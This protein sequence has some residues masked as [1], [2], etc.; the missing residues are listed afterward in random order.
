[1]RT[2]PE[3]STVKSPRSSPGGSCLAKENFR[4]LSPLLLSP[5]RV[6]TSVPADLSSDIE[7]GFV[8]S[9]GMVNTGGGTVTKHA[10]IKDS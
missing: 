9:F 5:A 7:I 4:V 10:K 8:V 2:I 3:S 1:M 6:I